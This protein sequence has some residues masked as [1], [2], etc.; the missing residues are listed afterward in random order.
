[1]TVYVPELVTLARRF[2]DALDTFVPHLAQDARVGLPGDVDDAMGVLIE[3]GA[4]YGVPISDDLRRDLLAELAGGD[5][6]DWFVA[7]ARAALGRMPRASNAPA[8]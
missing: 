5:W 3:R 6:E 1:M 4:S 2:A 8:A 7:E